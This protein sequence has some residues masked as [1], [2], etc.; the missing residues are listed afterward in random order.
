MA[1][2][3]EEAF[4]LRMGADLLLAISQED[5]ESLSRWIAPTNTG[6]LRF[7]R[8]EGGKRHLRRMTRDHPLMKYLE[9]D[10]LDLPR[11]ARFL[12]QTIANEK[13]ERFT[14]TRLL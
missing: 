11:A 2:W 8:K 7:Q 14:Q 1:R 13:L 12:A 10:P 5:T 6:G 4:D 9:R 3:A